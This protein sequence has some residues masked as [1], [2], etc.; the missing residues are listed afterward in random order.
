MSKELYKAQTFEGKTV[1]GLLVIHRCK[2]HIQLEHENGDYRYSETT[3]KLFKINPATLKQIGGVM[4]DRV[5]ELEEYIKRIER[6]AETASGD[7]QMGL[8]KALDFMEGDK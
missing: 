1:E 8:L 5:K 2:P 7:Y 4:V 6:K 3:W